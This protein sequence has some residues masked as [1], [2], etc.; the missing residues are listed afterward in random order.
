[1]GLEPVWA[2]KGLDPYAP[3]NMCFFLFARA[4]S[5]GFLLRTSSAGAE[6]SFQGRCS[7]TENLHFP[8]EKQGFWNWAWPRQ[9]PSLAHPGPVPACFQSLRTGHLFCQ[10]TRHLLRQQTRHL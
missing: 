6:L 1:M 10:E 4:T 8:K 2:H 5:E 3:P 7:T 9:V